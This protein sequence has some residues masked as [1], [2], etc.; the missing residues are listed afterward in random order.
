MKMPV[1]QKFPVITPADIEAMVQFFYTPIMAPTPV[2]TRL[3]RPADNADTI[4]GFLRVESADSTPLL[5]F[6]SA[7]WDMN[8][9]IHAYSPDEIEAS[10]IIARAMGEAA[11]AHFKT[12]MGFY[13]VD[14]VN[15]IG[16]N[17]L[18]EP[19]VPDLMRYRAAVTWR[20]AAN[21]AGQ[22]DSEIG[23]MAPALRG[24]G[25][26]GGS[27]DLTRIPTAATVSGAGA[28]SAAAVGQTVPSPFAYYDF[29]EAGGPSA[30]DVLGHLPNLV[31]TNPATAWSGPNAASEFSLSPLAAPLN[32]P[33]SICVNTAL[34]VFT[35]AFLYF[36][37]A[38][39]NFYL[40]G[41]PSDKSMAIY[42]GAHETRSAAN[43]LVS[44]ENRLVWTCDGS[45]EK[46]YANGVQVASGPYSAGIQT[47]LRVAEQSSWPAG[48]LIRDVSIW[49]VALTA[50]QVAAL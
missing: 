30:S 15:V 28:L 33:W 11:S 50:A 2:A 8:F 3:P 38:G 34:S 45:S 49:Q 27:V 41:Y 16:G 22:D 25:F 46:L 24:G 17:R 9:L 40:D 39:S 23:E 20:V 19:R 6:R 48:N 31:A 21:V 37:T 14:V 42:D 7:A 35:G 13:I 36:Y 10:S 32:P 12:V 4:N 29:H 43:V 44:G 18:P 1:A 47:Y 26:L 5:Q